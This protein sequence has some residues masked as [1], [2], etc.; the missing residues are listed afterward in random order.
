MG[1]LLLGSLLGHSLRAQDRGA[2]RFGPATPGDTIQADVL[3]AGRLWS[4]AEPPFDRFERRYEMKADSAWATHL[5]RGLL[6][7]PNCTA[8]LVSPKGPS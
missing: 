5:R 3:G 8:A 1:L 4:L 2:P 6:R 7:L